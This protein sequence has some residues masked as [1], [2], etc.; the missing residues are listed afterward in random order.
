MVQGI[1]GGD[2]PDHDPSRLEDAHVR[3]DGIAWLGAA[4]GPV[5]CFV[6]GRIANTE[7]GVLPRP[8]FSL[9]MVVLVA[10]AVACGWRAGC[11]AWHMCDASLV[12]HASCNT[13]GVS[14]LAYLALSTPAPLLL[15][16]G[17]PVEAS[18]VHGAD[19]AC[20][21]LADSTLL[22]TA[23]EV[24]CPCMHCSGKPSQSGARHAESSFGGVAVN[25][26]L[27]S[28]P[29]TVVSVQIWAVCT[30]AALAAL[31]LAGVPSSQ[32]PFHSAV[33]S[34]WLQCST[35]SVSLVWQLARAI[36]LCCEPFSMSTLP[37]S[38]LCLLKQSIGCCGRT[39]EARLDQVPQ[40]QLFLP[41][42]AITTPPTCFPVHL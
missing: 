18:T 10:V 22:C 34:S 9:M 25:R 2:L 4:Y 6:R 38:T 13:A 14:A 19:L 1:R 31:R 3:E 32:W 35:S 37:P 29:D 12:H 7:T 28:G 23:C 42:L 15:R 24:G 27:A 17:D 30:T 39:S 20:G 26:M 8:I 40:A 11:L 36:W 16:T 21:L 33:L 5:A 41:L